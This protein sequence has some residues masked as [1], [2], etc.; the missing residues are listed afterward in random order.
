MAGTTVEDRGAVN[1][2]FRETLANHGL[3]IRPDAID[4]VMGL[5]K[6]EALRILVGGSALAGTLIG[7]VDAMH[8]EFVARMVEFYRNDPTVREVPGTSDL[9]G[10]L[11]DAGVKVGLDTGFCR[12]IADVIIT[13]L[14]WASRGL[15][16]ASVASDEVANGR[17]M[18]DMIESLMGQLGVTSPRRVVKVGDAPADLEQGFAAKCRW[19]IGVTWGTHSRAQLERCTHTHLID[20]ME[21]LSV[22]LR[23]GIERKE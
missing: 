4:A 2:C 20:T 13:R 8:S 7:R 18:P 17:P 12:E 14:G 9:F 5:P 1:R 6:P 11:R 21:E 23:S 15:L 19:V 3:A 16:G 10:L 22:L